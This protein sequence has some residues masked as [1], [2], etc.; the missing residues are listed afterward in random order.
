MMNWRVEV[1]T[2]APDDGFDL[3]EIVD[4]SVRLLGSDTTNADFGDDGWIM[5]FEIDAIDPI[6]A[7]TFAAARILAAADLAFL[8][9]WPVVVVRVIDAELASAASRGFESP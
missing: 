7:L 6:E 9:L 5:Q 4:D 2:A 1:E 8:P 3:Q